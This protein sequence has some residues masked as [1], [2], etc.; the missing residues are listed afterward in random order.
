MTRLNQ[1][2]AVEKSVKGRTLAELTE[3]HHVLQTNE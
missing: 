2:I 1:I 3:A